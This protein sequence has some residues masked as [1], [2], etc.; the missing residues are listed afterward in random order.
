M[1]I[2]GELYTFTKNNI[3]NSPDQQ[4]VY[5]LYLDGLVIYYG[6]ATVSIRS[7]LQSHYRGDEGSCTKQ[8]TSCRGEVCS[9]PVAREAQLLEEHK[10]LYG[11]LPRCNERVG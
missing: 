10:R 11:R 7:R 2:E 8:A 1:P 5:A 6:R 4:G 9:N 3:D